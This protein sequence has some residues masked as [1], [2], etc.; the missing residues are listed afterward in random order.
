MVDVAH[1]TKVLLIKTTEGY[2]FILLLA[3]SSFYA[4]T[5]NLMI[6]AN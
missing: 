5:M 3:Y 4:K 1:R 2:N 6:L